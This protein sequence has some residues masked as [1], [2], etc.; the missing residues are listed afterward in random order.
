MKEP[1]QLHLM[2]RSEADE[3]RTKVLSML[4]S[5][6]SS[7]PATAG[8]AGETLEARR[9]SSSS[10]TSTVSNLLE[11]EP[12]CSEQPSASDVAV[13]SSCHSD[14]DEKLGGSRLI[15]SS[16]CEDVS[17]AEAAKGTVDTRASRLAMLQYKQGRL[18]KHGLLAKMAQARAAGSAEGSSDA[19]QSS[20]AP[21]LAAVEV[22]TL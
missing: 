17:T 10:A 12:S 8:S 20:D 22:I 3:A 5:I 6:S 16:P 2:Q 19:A 4:Q 9:R 13:S 15:N 11:T 18:S 14:S 7:L 21:V 1:A